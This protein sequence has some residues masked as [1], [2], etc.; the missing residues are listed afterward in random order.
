MSEHGDKKGEGPRPVGEVLKH[1]TGVPS[2]PKR[3]PPT[4]LQQ[5]LLNFVEEEGGDPSE[6]LY[7][8]SVLCQS[9]RR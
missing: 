1:L 6:I 3:S 9:W 5:R 8:H 4:P 7:Q 2:A